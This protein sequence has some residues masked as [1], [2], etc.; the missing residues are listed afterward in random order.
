MGLISRILSYTRVAGRFGANVSDIKHDSGGGANETSEHFQTA[1]VD[2]APLPGDYVAVMRIDGQRS[3]GKAVVAV[4]D[5]KQN[6]TASP[7]EFRAYSRDSGG[8]EQAQTHIMGDGRVVTSNANGV[9]VLHPD[10]V[11]ELIT[12]HGPNIFHTDGSVMFSNGATVTASGD[13]V[14]ASGVST[15]QHTHTQASD[16]AGNGQQP[17]DPPTPGV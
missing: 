1:N 11:I 6:Q 14:T 7:G 8:G 17:T 13:F 9:I 12:P 15:D 10:G 16:S 3:G 4:L 2:S 5:P